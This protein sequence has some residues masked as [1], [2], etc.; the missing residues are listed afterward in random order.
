MAAPYSYVLG[1]TEPISASAR[2]QR[3]DPG[4][5]VLLNLDHLAGS[6]RPATLS[7]P[8]ALSLRPSHSLVP[9]AADALRPS[10]PQRWWLMRVQPPSYHPATPDKAAS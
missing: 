1:Q 6:R 9:Q 4:S 2:S 7:S 8:T 3:A 10:R 5:S